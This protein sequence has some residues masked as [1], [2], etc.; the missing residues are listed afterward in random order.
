MAFVLTNQDKKFILFL[1]LQIMCNI[2]FVD[3]KDLKI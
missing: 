1:L 3:M 2:D